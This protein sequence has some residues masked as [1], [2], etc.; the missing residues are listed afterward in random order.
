MRFGSFC[1]VAVVAFAALVCLMADRTRAAQS[2][3]LVACPQFTATTH[4]KLADGG[5][6][7]AYQLALT[8]DKTACSDAATWA[9]KLM[10]GSFSGDLPVT[11][12]GP[13]GY[14]CKLTPD[15]YGGVIG[16]TCHKSDNVSGWDWI[17][18]TP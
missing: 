12:K 7:N 5:S 1:I 11:V 15:G 4:W 16:G 6:G 14:V 17:G 10:K 13:A 18:V 8:N 9:K 2:S 3:N